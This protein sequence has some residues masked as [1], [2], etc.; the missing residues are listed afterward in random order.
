MTAFAGCV[1]RQHIAA[2][3]PLLLAATGELVVEK[4]GVL[5]L[6]VEGMML[7]GAI[8]AFATANETGSLA[9]RARRAGRRDALALMFA[10][11][12]LT[13]Q[14]NQTATGLAL[15][16][17]GR[18]FSALVGAGYVGI[19]RRHCRSCI[20][21][22]LSDIPVL[23]PVCFRT[24]SWSISRWRSSRWS[25]GAIRSTHLGLIFRAV[26]D[27]HDAAH[28]LGLCRGADPLRGRGVRRRAGGL[29][30][31]YMSLAYT[32]LWAQDMTAGRGWVALAL[33]T[34]AAWRPFWLLIGAWFFGAL[35]YLSLYVQALG[36]AV[37][38]A[39]LSALPYIGTVVVLVLI[40]RDAG[41]SGCT[42]RR[43]WGGRSRRGPEVA[44]MDRM[45][46]RWIR[47]PLGILAD[48]A[49]GG[50]VVR[51]GRIEE[52]IPSGGQ[53]SAPRCGGVR[54]RRSCRAARP[55]QHASSF[56]P[57]TDPGHAGS[58]GSAAVRL[59]D[60]ALSDL[61]RLTPEAMDAAATAALAELLLSG[62]TTTTDHH[63][64]FPP[65]LD[66]AIDI[67][68]AAAQRLGIR[69]TVTRGSMNR[70]QRDGGLPPDDV[71]QDEDTILAD[72]ERLIARYH[73][74]GPDALVQVALAPCSPFSVTTSLMRKSAELAARTGVHLHTH[75][76]ETEDE[77]RFCQDLHGC[78][79]LDYL[80]QCGWLHDKVWLAH[81]VHFNAAR[82]RAWP[83]PGRP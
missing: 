83:A 43:C 46:A 70:S 52:L 41:A 16:I 27:S 39:L 2:A 23:G 29:A 51:G 4:V 8:A 59:A 37:P 18:G 77:N 42:G 34:F 75:L 32:P 24:I 6:G 28:A 1:P 44:G 69:V 36:V 45:A 21:P 66:Q 19:P 65:G 5:N 25:R 11:I 58:A 76:A 60:R 38:S 50:V 74:T 53:P 71:V 20:F 49:A 30:G 78:R 64:V 40:S 55:D 3:T 47:N 79:P 13:L 12:S 14:A 82:W 7:A 26:G 17:F 9:G 57:N 67:E 31:A 62:C 68:I 15:T 35:M 63:Y 56:L 22:V 33:V 48:G 61:G 10:V 80:E 54:R 73:Q 72:S 81:G